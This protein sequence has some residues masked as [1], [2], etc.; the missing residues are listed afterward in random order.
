VDRGG[1]VRVV[2]ANSALSG[3]LAEQAGFDAVWASSLEISAMRCLPD[4]SLLTMTD[5]LRAAADV[6]RALG[7][8]VIADCDTGFGNTMNV[9]YMVME[10]EAAG[11]TAI[12]LEDKVFPKM[13]SFAEGDHALVDVEDFADKIRTVKATQRTPD[14][15][16][17]ARTEALISGL[18]CDEA[19]HRCA[20][21]ADAGADA[22]LI[23][24]K[25]A[26]N[27]EVMEFLDRWDGR[28]PV[29]VVPTTYPD[30]HA[31]DLQRCGVSV[32]IYANHGLRTVIGALRDSYMRILR[33]GHTALLD[34]EIARV[35][36]V[37]AL[38]LLDEWQQL[39]K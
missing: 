22:V 37:F 11:I 36:D 5:Y 34:K 26:T 31:A 18:G 38:L 16:V 28:R 8:P 9:A 30:W 23:H 2:G 12:C 24:S 3:M 21:Y 15:F 35:S 32:V 4:A 33:D 13:N 20:A 29:V 7:I 39:L 14:F 10:Y 25:H 1:L 6:Q 17:V 19:L 27:A